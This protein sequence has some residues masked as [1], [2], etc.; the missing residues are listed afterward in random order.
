MTAPCQG[1]SSTPI[2][3]GVADTDIVRE[4]DRSSILLIRFRLL[5]DLS[6]SM[7]ENLLGASCVAGACNS[8]IVWGDSDDRKLLWSSRIGDCR[9]A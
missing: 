3:C 7:V 8:H 4:L 6:I 1:V 9:C 2:K 5:I